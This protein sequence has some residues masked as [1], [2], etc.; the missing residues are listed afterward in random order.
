MTPRSR[1]ISRGRGRPRKTPSRPSYDDKP[2]NASKEEVLKWQRRKN[3]DEWRYTKLTSEDVD[4]YRESKNQM[5]KWSVSQNHQQI[6]DAAAGKKSVYEHVP[7][8]SPK[9]RARE[10]SRQR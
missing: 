8:S 4:A 6:I 7:D 10:K 9:M 1:F 5:V 3:T 2:V